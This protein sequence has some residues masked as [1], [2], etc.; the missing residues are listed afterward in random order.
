VQIAR[1]EAANIEALHKFAETH[2]IACEMKPSMT[3]D[4]VYDQH[5]WRESERAVEAMRE[6]MPGDPASAYTL[7][8]P[9]LIYSQFR[10]E[11]ESDSEREV[12]GGVQYA[13]G[14]ISAYLFVIGVIKL[15]LEQGLNLQTNTPV[16]RVSM[17]GEAVD[18]YSWEVET[19]S[20]VIRAKRVVLATNGYTAFLRKRFQGVLVPVRGQIAAQRPGATLRT[21]LPTTTYSFIYSGGFD[22]MIPRSI[23]SSPRQAWHIIIGGGLGFA[24]MGG[25][26]EIG[27]TDDSALNPEISKHLRS[28]LANY[29]GSHWGKDNTQGRVVREWSGIM[30][31]TADHLPFIGEMP[32]EKDLWVCAGFQGHGM[33]LAWLCARALV[34]MIAGHDD[35][36]VREWFPDVFRVTEQRFS[37][38]FTG[39]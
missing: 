25:I 21:Q 16:T 18:G 26:D 34:A 7:L 15:C 14:G 30:G 36:E 27:V 12:F 29:F 10:C 2:K 13:A 9:E 23:T 22:Y 35:A 17:N 33:V 19:S 38:T 28:C 6:A 8:S 32:G 1:F 31:F 3:I 37:Q 20:G 24:R 11:G 5:E 39:I 4:V